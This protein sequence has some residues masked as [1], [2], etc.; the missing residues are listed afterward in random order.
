MLPLI[1]FLLKEWTKFEFEVG[2]LVKTYLFVASL[3]TPCKSR[4]FSSKKK[5]IVEKIN[6]M[7]HSRNIL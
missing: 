4:C 1:V 7:D 2:A 5:M 6:M 3:N